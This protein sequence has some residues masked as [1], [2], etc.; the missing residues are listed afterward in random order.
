MCLIFFAINAHT[1]FPLIVA[2]NRDEYFQRPTLP[3]HGW[4]N[5]NIVAGKDLTGGG[6]W[7]GMSKTGRFAALT[8][9]R[10]PQESIH[11]PLS[12]GLL[13]RQFLES[14]QSAPDYLE[15]VIH[16]GHRYPGFNLVAGQG[17]QLWYVSNKSARQPQPLE[18]GIHG[19]SNHLMN[20]PWPK[21]SQ[22]KTALQQVL[23]R[24]PHPGEHTLKNSL[25]DLMN[26]RE[27]AADQ[28]LPDSG[29]GAFL[30]KV[31][32]PR[33]IQAPMLNY[34]TRCSSVILINNERHH[35][36][37]EKTWDSNGQE[38]DKV[39]LKLT[40]GDPC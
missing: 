38:V 18:A 5:S 31:L 12:R 27:P 32:S 29:V 28:D 30:E 23:Q 17:H 4:D 14:T 35:Y 6:T 36:L 20:T 24:N 1:E 3:M 16:E 19:L 22:G 10:D 7:M 26:H 13:V 11:N 33:F 34:G 2:A 39:E 40:A 21:V 25:F 9:F 15:S 37:F 8:N